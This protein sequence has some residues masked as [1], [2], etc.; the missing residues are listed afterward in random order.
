M[1]KPVH[2][3]VKKRSIL[4]VMLI[5]ACLGWVVGL[6]VFVSTI[7]EHAA[8][9]EE[10]T[11]AIIVL[12][13]GSLRLETGIALLEAGRA[14]KLFVS[15]VHRGVEAREI[16]GFAAKDPRFFECCVDLGHD[17]ADTAGNATETA[18]WVERNEIA[19]IRLVTAAYHMPRALLEVEARMPEVRIL[20]HPVFPERVKLNSWFRFPGTAV[21]VSIEYSKY[22]LA[23]IRINL[24]RAI[25]LPARMLR[26]TPSPDVKS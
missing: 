8:Q 1:A 6:P 2:R 23:A 14:P 11:D 18:L 24:T 4:S 25:N 22:L 5:I 10:A 20:P 3:R 13:G 7:P 9:T 19:S 12:T 16:A 26:G 17:A 21:L 15:G